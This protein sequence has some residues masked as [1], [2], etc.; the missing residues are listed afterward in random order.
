[1]SIAALQGPSTY[2]AKPLGAQ[3]FQTPEAAAAGQQKLG[4]VQASTAWMRA[5]EN[6]HPMKKQ[7]GQKQAVRELGI[8]QLLDHPFFA[9]EAGLRKNKQARNSFNLTSYNLLKYLLKFAIAM[10]V[11]TVTLLSC[12]M[13][14]TTEKA[15]I[16]S[17]QV[18]YLSAQM[19]RDNDSIPHTLCIIYLYP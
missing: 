10:F 16:S 5:G 4:T 13:S 14:C 17:L 15:I 11:D 2:K 8:D 3:D 19:S 9:A 18:S 7:R 6:E 12:T 1:M